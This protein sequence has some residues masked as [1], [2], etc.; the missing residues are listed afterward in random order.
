MY[1]LPLSVPC[2]AIGVEFPCAKIF[3]EE[4]EIRITLQYRGINWWKHISNSSIEITI[5]FGIECLWECTRPV[6]NV[7]LRWV[8]ELERERTSCVSCSAA[9]SINTR[10]CPDYDSVVIPII[11][12]LIIP[13]VAKVEPYMQ[14]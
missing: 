8:R 2:R 9:W 13:V 6:V 11:N 12:A 5:E 10:T 4:V 7:C 14:G 3:V 1:T